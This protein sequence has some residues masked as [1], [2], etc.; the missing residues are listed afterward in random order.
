MNDISYDLN[1]WKTIAIH[2]ADKYNKKFNIV[3]S[4]HGYSCCPEG[5]KTNCDVVWITDEE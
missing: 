3:D 5:A 1:Y 4:N 2:L